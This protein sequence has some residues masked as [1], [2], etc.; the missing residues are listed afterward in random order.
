MNW[1]NI[2]CKTCKHKKKCKGKWSK[3]SSK[4]QQM[5]GLEEKKEEKQLH[6]HVILW[7]LYNKYK[8]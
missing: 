2:S 3:G 5:L 6:P 7:G 1:N 4:C 8:V